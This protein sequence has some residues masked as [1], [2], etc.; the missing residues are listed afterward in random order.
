M[1]AHAVTILISFHRRNSGLSTVSCGKMVSK[2]SFAFLIH[3]DFDAGMV[4]SESVCRKLRLYP[5][6]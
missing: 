2:F 6:L 1:Q 3:A 5:S 4:S